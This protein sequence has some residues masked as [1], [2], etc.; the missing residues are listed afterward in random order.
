MGRRKKNSFIGVAKLGFRPA[1]QCVDYSIPEFIST[2]LLPLDRE[3]GGGIPLS[4]Q[5]EIYGPESSAKSS[6]ALR[7]AASAQKQDC[8][9]YL[10]ENE[11]TFDIERAKILGV[12]INSLYVYRP[13]TLEE[14]FEVIKS[15]IKL[16]IKDKDRKGLLIWD[17]LNATQAMEEEDVKF[18]DKRPSPQARAISQALRRITNKLAKTK[19]GIIYINQTRKKVGLLFG[20]PETTPGGRALKF[21]ASWRLAIRK[22]KIIKNDNSIPVGIWCALETKKNKITVP[23]RKLEIPLMFGKRGFDEALLN[24]TYL[25]QHKVLK[26]NSTGWIEWGN[27]KVKPKK[28]IKAARQDNKIM[29]KLEKFIKGMK[30]VCEEDAYN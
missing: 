1:I 23:F 15:L 19:L 5:V 3:L 11:G 29:K 8:E 7:I 20:D 16:F 13:E 27:K 6:L 10:L 9:V 28:L 18:G 21:Y 14:G 17:T 2:G 22:K 25:V 4:R 24:V 30:P 12:D 26:K